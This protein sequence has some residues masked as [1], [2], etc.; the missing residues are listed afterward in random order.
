MG[1]EEEY[2]ETETESNSSDDEEDE[3]P[4]RWK[5]HYSSKHRMLL[6]G[7]G[8]F[9]FSVS[10]ARAFGSA[11]NLVS[12][13]VDTQDN[14]A[15]KY[16]NGV[17]NVRELEEKG[18]LVFYGVD[19]KEMS[20]HFFLRTQRFDRI[21]FNFPHVGFLF[22]EASYCQIQLNKSLIKGYLSNAKVLLKQ[23][24][25]EIHVTHK[26]GDPYDKWDLVKKAEKIG[27]G[28]HE[29]VPF[30]R[31]DYPGYE[32]KRAHGSQSDAPFP[33]GNSNTSQ[34][35]AYGYTGM[36]AICGV[37]SC[38][39]HQQVILNLSNL[40][41]NQFKVKPQIFSMMPVQDKK[42]GDTNMG[43]K[44]SR[45]QDHQHRD[46]FGCRASSN[47]CSTPNVPS[48][49][50]YD[51]GRSKPQSRYSRIGDDYH[52]LE[53]VT[54]AL[55][56]AGLESSNLI[57]GI[58]FTKSNEWTGARSF[59]RKSLHH[60]GDSMNPYEQA[61]SI[62]GRTLSAFDEDNL[63]PCFGFGDATTHDQ[64]VFSFYPDDQLCNGFEEVLSRYREIVPRVNLAGPT[65]FAPIIETAI[66]IVDNSCGQYHV[67][68]IIADGQVTSSV[69]A[70]NGKLSSQ[71]QNT[72]NAIVRASNYPLSI[73]LVGVGDGPWDMM[74]KF[75]DN[76][77]SRAF[78][79]FQ[80][81]NFTEIM[82]KNIPMSKKE[83]VCSGRVNGNTIPIQGYNRPPTP[84]HCPSCLWNKKDLAF[85]CGHQTSDHQVLDYKI[86]DQRGDQEEGGGHK[87]LEDEEEE[88]NPYVFE[89]DR[90]F[91]SR[92]K[93]EH[94]RVDVLQQF[95]KNSNLLSALANYR[96]E[97][98]E[99][100]P[101]TFITPAHID[102]DFVLFVVKGRGAITV[103]HEEIKRETSN[104]ECGDIFRVHADTT[105]YMVNRDEY[106]K[107]YVAKIL[108]PV[109]LPGN[110]EAFYGAG[111][112][113]S[114]SFFEAFS[115][116]LVEAALNTE[117]GRLEK[118]F[119]QQQGKI[120]NATKQ[121]IEALSQD[122]EGVRGSNGA[123]PFP[124]NVSGSPFNLFKK[125]AIKSNNYGDLYEADPRDFKPLE[126]LNLIVSFAN[127]TQAC[128]DICL[129]LPSSHII[130]Q[131]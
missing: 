12:T 66:E 93:T 126:Y 15:K 91:V 106:E 27:L 24:K 100:N 97:I 37:R 77:P 86:Q 81:V 54:R 83:T 123:W 70:V 98:L 130:I 26:E 120:M 28:L 62:I 36:L 96:V 1:K 3:E 67:L 127:I 23:D 7:E 94:G 33:L 2:Q 124:S 38:N 57:V 92:V 5:K 39:Y 20:G 114:E 47:P 79:N 45:H 4:E 131:S 105:F 32:N 21:V 58:D 53:Q 108:F 31:G 56:Q 63:I 128:S 74:H 113:D 55:A 125:G 60:L 80:L 116:D 110:Y 11:C 65:S 18:G 17:R 22:P 101:L 9:S 50:V 76:I 85:G 78:D 118:I 41:G 43:C 48:Y 46:S 117:R 59:H 68:L 72:I 75:D 102:A 69:G 88:I 111:G 115:W 16:S 42:V 19:A 84:R 40:S 51:D 35:K 10:L 8:D 6:V 25:G 34:E 95:T 52:S 64:K 107:L 82:S 129:A 29:I 103:I 121:Q 89:Y 44:H 122:E 30:S 99:A 61:I 73:V 87:D 13:T 90:D 14:I 104:L 49:A 112:G 109:N 119:K 71:E